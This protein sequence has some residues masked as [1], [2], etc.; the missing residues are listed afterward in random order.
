M[1]FINK[2]V[3]KGCCSSKT[4]N[5]QTFHFQMRREI[6]LVR[7]FSLGSSASAEKVAFAPAWTMGLN[8][9]GFPSTIPH[10]QRLQ[11]DLGFGFMSSCPR[12][13][14]KFCTCFALDTFGTSRLTFLLGNNSPAVQGSLFALANSALPGDVLILHLSDPSAFQNT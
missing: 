2:A 5:R 12:T 13:E 9:P 3:K 14:Q 8:I 1:N 11:K 6:W 4:G 10:P 7:G